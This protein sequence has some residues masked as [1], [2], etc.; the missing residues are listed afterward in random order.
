MEELENLQNRKALDTTLKR[1]E[2]AHIEKVLAD[3]DIVRKHSRRFE[4]IASRIESDKLKKYMPIMIGLL[5][6]RYGATMDTPLRSVRRVV[7]MYMAMFIVGHQWLQA[8]TFIQFNLLSVIYVTSVMPYDQ[9]SK[10]FVT[11]FN[12][13]FCLLSA[14]FI[15]ALQDLRFDPEKQWS[16]GEAVIHILYTAAVMNGLVIV[17]KILREVIVKIR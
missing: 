13:T 2:S 9:A 5:S 17:V 8:L 10:N 16:I 6:H 7:L 3:I 15:L 11:I 1:Q 14:Y 12:E 4:E